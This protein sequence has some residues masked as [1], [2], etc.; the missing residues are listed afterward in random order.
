MKSAKPGVVSTKMIWTM[1][2]RT[3]VKYRDAILERKFAMVSLVA[4][5]ILA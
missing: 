5:D 3:R 4:R 1:T 2:T